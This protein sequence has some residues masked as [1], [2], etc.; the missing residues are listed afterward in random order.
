MFP[1]LPNATLTNPASY[2][3]EPAS[4]PGA[5]IPVRANPATTHVAAPVPRA[6]LTGVLPSRVRVG[7]RV[8]KLGPLL[9]ALNENER[10]HLLAALQP[11]AVQCMPPMLEPD[12]EGA[13]SYEAHYPGNQNP[14]DPRRM[15]VTLLVDN[16]GNL[17]AL[18]A[19]SAQYGV[20]LQYTTPLVR[21][22]F[23]STLEQHPALSTFTRQPSA[24]RESSTRAINI[25][26][27]SQLASVRPGQPLSLGGQHFE[28]AKTAD[29]GFTVRLLDRRANIRRAA[30]LAL[31]AHAPGY[32]A[33]ERAHAA[34]ELT[35]LKNSLL[36]HHPEQ[37]ERLCQRTTELAGR[38][39]VPGSDMR[40]KMVDALSHYQ[41]PDGDHVLMN[42]A[43]LGHKTLAEYLQG[44]D[45]QKYHCDEDVDEFCEDFIENYSYHGYE[46]SDLRSR[47]EDD[48]QNDI[49]PL[50]DFLNSGASIND[51]SLVKGLKSNI[52]MVRST[53]VDMASFVG[54]FVNQEKIHYNSFLST[55]ASWSNSKDFTGGS[56][57]CVHAQMAVD[58]H[59]PSPASMLQ[60]ARLLSELNAPETRDDN[61][62]IMMV[63]HCK[64]AKG[65]VLD[66]QTLGLGDTLSL[67]EQEI[68]LAPNHVVHPQK[69]I[70]TQDGYVLVGEVGVFSR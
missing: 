42:I 67:D 3:T 66:S 7:N 28:A 4:A 2:Q 27:N 52:D 11:A 5:A 21:A 1:R 31:P 39:L 34:Q 49:R 69:V 33:Q 58:L 43:L 37:L 54:A 48:I 10:A 57:P 18:R 64:N 44:I 38:L 60:R 30:L 51:V 63:L 8:F 61:A 50:K 32:T 16:R 13:L 6:P 70:R 55:S 45:P 65:V 46:P 24:L 22:H 41:A 40:D 20:N 23:A 15:L 25:D 35:A 19:T 36:E 62:F 53:A 59:D 17:T 29:N 68:L 14:A 56:A 12:D 26:S 47:F 9:Q